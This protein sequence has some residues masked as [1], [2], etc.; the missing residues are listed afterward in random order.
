MYQN[1]LCPVDGS[2]SSNRGLAEAV[3]L[4]ANQNAQL[5]L[6]HVVDNGPLLMYMP[7]TAS[8]F[9]TA[10]EC[11]RMVLAR[12]GRVAEEQRVPTTSRLAEILN[13]R[14]AT[15]IIDVA[16]QL[17]P[18][19]IVMGTNG[20]RGI[21]RLLLGSDAASVVAAAQVPVMLVR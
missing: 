8:N 10:R 19:L 4:A 7:I 6:L 9:E 5:H 1:I 2:E 17:Q 13:G 15:A 18:D 20:R 21:S 11:G 14:P 16:E 12:A 3:R